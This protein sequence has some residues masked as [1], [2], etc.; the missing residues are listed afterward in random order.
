MSVRK[1][2]KTIRI[3]LV[4]IAAFASLVAAQQREPDRPG[5]TLVRQALD[6]ATRIEVGMK[7]RELRASF[8]L[9]GGMQF[10]TQG[11][12]VYRTC[13]YIKMEVEFEPISSGDPH[14]FSDEDR[15]IRVSKLSIGFPVMD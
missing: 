2:M 4:A 3:L 10:R 13:Q 1:V 9:E 12:Y 7:R 6:A 11:R 15:I 5:C 8:L 14:L